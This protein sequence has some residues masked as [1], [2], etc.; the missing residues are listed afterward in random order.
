MLCILNIFKHCEKLK[1]VASSQLIENTT[2]GPS[3][4]KAYEAKRKMGI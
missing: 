1:D 4:R 3:I 2:Y